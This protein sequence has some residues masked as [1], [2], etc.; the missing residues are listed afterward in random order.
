MKAV[1]L[2]L[3][4]WM[5]IATMV[6]STSLLIEA[7]HI[8]WWTYIVIMIVSIIVFCF[9]WWYYVAKGVEKG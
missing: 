1:I 9:S 3:G 2:K 8:N 5:A 4:M 7:E 6:L